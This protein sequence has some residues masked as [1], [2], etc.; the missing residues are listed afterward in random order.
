MGDNDYG[1]VI[2]VGVLDELSR[3]GY[4]NCFCLEFRS[5]FRYV[6]KPQQL[7][8]PA[9]LLYTPCRAGR[10]RHGISP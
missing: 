4:G 9:P 2:C 5:R 8:F 10:N 6:A 1:A 3:R 7:G